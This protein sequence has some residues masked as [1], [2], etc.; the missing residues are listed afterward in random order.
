MFGKIQQ[1]HNI[2]CFSDDCFTETKINNFG[3]D[4]IDLINGNSSTILQSD[5]KKLAIRQILDRRPL[6]GT[7]HLTSQ[8]ISVKM[9]LRGDTVEN[10]AVKR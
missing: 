7:K 5:Q 9:Y 1:T 2:S 3:Q 10:I 8:L 6:P 4:F